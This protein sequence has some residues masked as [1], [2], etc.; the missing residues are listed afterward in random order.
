MFCINNWFEISFFFLLCILFNTY[1]N[2]PINIPDLISGY[3]LICLSY[4][5]YQ[6]QTETVTMENNNEY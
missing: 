6:E 3:S 5:I 2:V 1:T 4:D